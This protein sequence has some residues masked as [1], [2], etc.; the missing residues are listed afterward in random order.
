MKLLVDTDAFRKLAASGLLHAAVN[1][2][3]ANPNECGRL[4]ALPH[5]LKRGQLR[6]ANG[7]AGC[8]QMIPIALSMPIVLQADD[9]WLDKLTQVQAIDIGEAQLFAVGAETGALVMTGDK[10][11]LRA[12]KNIADFPDA[13]AGR[14]VALE[15]ILI[16]LCDRLGPENV[17]Q[18]VQVLAPS[19]RMVQSCFST[20]NSDPRDGLLSYYGELKGEVEPM[21]LWNPRPEEQV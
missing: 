20:G 13:L 11:A 7:S 5:M 18:R 4:P 16:A 17:R 12:L 1:L 15:A 9:I 19:D 2:L 21:V 10:R 8:D 6:S 14:I 3:G